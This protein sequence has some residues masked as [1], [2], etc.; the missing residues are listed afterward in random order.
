MHKALIDVLNKK[1]LVP[2]TDWRW[3]LRAA[4]LESEIA[5]VLGGTIEAIRSYQLQRI[6]QICACSFE[7]SDFCRARIN[8][9][10][11]QDFETMT[12]DDFARIRPTTK[13][14]IREQLPAMISRKATIESLRKTATGGTTTS[15][16]TFYMDWGT[17][18]KRWATSYFQDRWMSRFRGE[19]LA[20]L[21]GA[22][23]DFPQ[24]SSLKN[25]IRNAFSNVLFLRS[26]PLD[27]A[28]FGDYYQRLKTFSP[29]HL[30]A[31]ATPLSMF[32][33]FLLDRGLELKIPS[34]SVTAEPL[35][36]AAADRIEQ[37]F[38]SR[39][40]NWYGARE[41]GRIAT[42]CSCRKGM[43]VNCYSLY[44]EVASGDKYVGQN[45]GEA[46]ITD[47]W[48]IGMP[49]LRY[50]IEDVISVDTERCD[51][52][53]ELPRIMNVAG[54]V[55]DTF[56]NYK[57]QKIPGVSLTNRIMS[58]STEVTQAQFIQRN[59]RD[60]EVLIVPGPDWSQHAAQSLH[61]ALEEFLQ[62]SIEVEFRLVDE[63][64]RE[65]SGK[66]RFCK[67][68]VHSVAQEKID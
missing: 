18:H 39:P 53:R 5:T 43:H 2:W 68:H 38:G 3:G 17:F 51:C 7:H 10:G 11:I 15:P 30:Q 14:E 62:E 31:Y 49:L 54:R 56:V 46:I 44:V 32:A 42:E 55:A 24:T 66:V 26:T 29:R 61:R 59:L 28:T 47:L 67:S 60:F 27:E 65:P 64:P 6:R 45:Q 21:W 12:L 57:G 36:A 33:D 9:A 40:Y 50:Q 48:N 1:M 41:L 20:Y 23:Q 34:I 16:T 25:K 37:A 63:I 8:E 4:R 22:P 58:G 13:S 35:L 52:G 19:R